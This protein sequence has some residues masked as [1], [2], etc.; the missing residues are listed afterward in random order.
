MLFESFGAV[1][2]SLSIVTMVVSVAICE[3]FSVKEWCTVTTINPSDVVRDLGVL[4]D[5]ELTMKKHI[6]KVAAVCFFN[7]RR[8]RQNFVKIFN[9][10]KTRMIGLP[11][12]GK[13]TM[14]IC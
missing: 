7:I 6:A 12:G 4:F 8:L 9:A 13:K 1:S 2:Y 10:G 14:T 5:A 3:I 11:Y